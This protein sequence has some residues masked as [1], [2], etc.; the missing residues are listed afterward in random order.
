M[1]LLLKE[2]EHWN[3]TPEYS[4]GRI[5]LTGGDKTARFHYKNILEE[6]PDL[7]LQLILD[8][9][10]FRECLEERAAIREAEGLLGDLRSAFLKNHDTFLT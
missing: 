9:P 4:F 6:N 1:N 8:V 2:L 10:E 5:V 3:I 7:E